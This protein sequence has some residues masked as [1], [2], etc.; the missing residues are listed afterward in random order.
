YE[1]IATPEAEIN[2]E[3]GGD[4]ADALRY[5]IG[6]LTGLLILISGILLLR[7]GVRGRLRSGELT[8]R[9]HPDTGTTQFARNKPPDIEFQ[10]VLDPGLSQAQS[11][12]IPSEGSLIRSNWRH[13]G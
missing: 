6:G 9:A 8:F 11:R 4:F 2:V 13:D 7:R 12:T 10:I 1:V 5:L 3:P